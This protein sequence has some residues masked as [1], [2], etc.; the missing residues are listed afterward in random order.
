MLQFG[1][2]QTS[3]LR[4]CQMH[5]AKATDYVSIDDYAKDVGLEVV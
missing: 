1:V 2:Q 5:K 3:A 4:E